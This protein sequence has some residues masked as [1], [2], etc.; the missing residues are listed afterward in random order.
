MHCI[1]L[2]IAEQCHFSIWLPQIT[3]IRW[4][5]V[6]N[7]KQTH[8]NFRICVEWFIFYIFLPLFHSGCG[9]NIS[10]IFVLSRHFVPSSTAAVAHSV[11]SVEQQQQQQPKVHFTMIV[12]LLKICLYILSFTARARVHVCV[13]VEI[14]LPNRSPWSSAAVWQT[15][16]AVAATPIDIRIASTTEKCIYS[17]WMRQSYCF[18][19]TQNAKCVSEM[20]RWSRRTNCHSL[21]NKSIYRK[22][23]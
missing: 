16:A 11:A 21:R 3:S 10:S 22:V 12:L 17:C 6:V 7:W 13:C 5:E 4:R 18:V 2:T 23:K 15:A 1:F 8:N 9:C 19:T 20:T 14:F